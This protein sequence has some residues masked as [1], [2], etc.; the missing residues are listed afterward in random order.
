MANGEV[1]FKD[2][3]TDIPIY[4]TSTSARWIIPSPRIGPY[5]LGW[6]GDP[7]DIP[8]TLNPALYM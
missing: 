5:G 6:G 8:V 7:S 1:G 2:G 3:K 4:Q